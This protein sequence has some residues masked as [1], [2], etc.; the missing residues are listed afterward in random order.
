MCCTQ[1]ADAVCGRFPAWTGTRETAQQRIDLANYLIDL[2]RYMTELLRQIQEFQ[3]LPCDIACKLPTGGIFSH[4][5]SQQLVRTV[6]G[7]AKAET[8]KSE[9]EFDQA[10]WELKRNGR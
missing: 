1:Q 7:I 3:V 2:A 5:S 8:D 10:V 6:I 4:Y 9:K